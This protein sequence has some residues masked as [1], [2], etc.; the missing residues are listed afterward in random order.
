MEPS[1]PASL[2]SVFVGLA[3]PAD[4]AGILALHQ[5]VVEEGDFFISEPD[6]LRESLESKVLQIQDAARS[7]RAVWY[8]AR[9]RNRVVGMAH[10][11]AA[12]RRR[13]R[14]VARIELMI[15][16]PDR[17]RGIGGALLDAVIHWAERHPFVH[18]L[19]LQV[20]AHNDAAIALY[21]RRGFVEE[22]RRVREYLF[23]DGSW[24][25]DL[26]MGRWVKE[27]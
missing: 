8:V 5:R 10:A 3:V 21:R 4:A 13:N 22:G 15:D 16:R 20:F 6:E 7:G 18:K 26:M 2:G 1:L 12:P 23:P 19:S 25:D 9:R 11:S 17:G 27:G 14:H 24:R